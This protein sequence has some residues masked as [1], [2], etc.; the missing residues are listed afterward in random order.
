MLPVFS[1]PLEL[2]ALVAETRNDLEEHPLS[3]EFVV[4]KKAWSYWAKGNGLVY[5]YDDHEELDSKLQVLAN[6]G[7]IPAS[8]LRS[9]SAV[10]RSPVE[11]SDVRIRQA[12]GFI[13]RPHCNVVRRWIAEGRPVFPKHRPRQVNGLHEAM[14]I[15]SLA[16]AVPGP[17]GRYPAM[18]GS[19]LLSSGVVRRE[20]LEGR[21]LEGRCTSDRAAAMHI[22]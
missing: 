14:T 19:S 11:N 16:L 9:L 8:S 18:A 4:L 3:R 20:S 10:A 5:F 21:H 17:I 13:H 6:L 7:L 22:R 1:R 2:S 15:S 12:E